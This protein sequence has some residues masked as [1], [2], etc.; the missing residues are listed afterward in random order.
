MFL[1]LKEL[2]HAKL[3]FSLVVLIMVLIAW[4]VLFVTGLANGLASDNGSAIESS[5]ATGFLVE[6]DSDNRLTRSSLSEEKVQRAEEKFGKNATALGVQMTTVTKPSAAKKTDVTFFGIDPSRFLVPE[7]VSGS[8]L[9]ENQGNVV[10]A[11]EKLKESGYKLGDKVKDQMSGAVFEITGFAKNATYSHTPVLYTNF[12]SFK[13]LQQSGANSYN[14]VALQGGSGEGFT[15]NG[16]VYASE[17]EVLENIPGYS[18]EQGSLLMMIVFLFVIAAFVLA[19]F[20][21][22][23]T[24]QKM[25]Q[26]GV[27]KAVGAK[28]SYLARSIVF[29]VVFLA[30]VSLV[31]SNALTFLMALALPDSMPFNLSPLTAL[32]CSGLFILMAVLGSI[33]SLSR[34]VRVDALEAIG[35]AN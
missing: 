24:I 27:L 6:K 19:A 20:F 3:K 31:I 33:L 16:L 11:D 26:L 28:T 2:K 25:N 34:V 7:K 13:K 21:Y 15:Q 30:F 8:S 17:K 12:D 32:F 5:K 22:V 4:L 14:A 18:E 10:I 23:I 29:Q 9:A 1:A 35:R